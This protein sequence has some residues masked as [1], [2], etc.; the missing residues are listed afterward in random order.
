MPAEKDTPEIETATTMLA[1]LPRPEQKIAVEKLREII[2]D[3]ED[4]RKWESLLEEHPEPLLNMAA[5]AE[6]EIAAGRFEPLKF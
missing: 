3:I 1:T 5:S 4:D 2:H 6:K